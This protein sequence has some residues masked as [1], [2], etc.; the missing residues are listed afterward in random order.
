MPNLRSFSYEGHERA[1]GRLVKWTDGNDERTRSGRYG[2]RD[3]SKRRI[4]CAGG[5]EDP[6]DFSSLSLEDNQ[7]RGKP[8][9][10]V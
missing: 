10:D 5:R 1:E 2:T 8:K 3:R 9:S 6:L 7:H 4:K